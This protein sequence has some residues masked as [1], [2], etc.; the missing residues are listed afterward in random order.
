MGLLSHTRVLT[1]INHS[2]VRACP[3]V[4]VDR[5]S[6]QHLRAVVSDLH[7]TS[8]FLMSCLLCLLS[9]SLASC[10][11]LPTPGNGNF[12]QLTTAAGTTMYVICDYGYQPRTKTNLTCLVDGTW[13]NDVPVCDTGQW[14]THDVLV[15]C[16]TVCM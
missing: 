6:Q 5:G 4:S 13:D 11:T 8:A 7:V 2:L 16:D 15:P 12:S 9:L 14:Y 10:P 3:R 1:V